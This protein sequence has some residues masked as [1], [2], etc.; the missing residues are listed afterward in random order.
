MIKTIDITFEKAIL[1]GCVT[2]WFEDGKLKSAYDNRSISQD[3]AISL[4]NEYIENMKDKLT[5]KG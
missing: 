3:E 1:N 2:V 4:I 5:Q